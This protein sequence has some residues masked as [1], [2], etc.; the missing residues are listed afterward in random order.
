M[1]A[2]ISP[3]ANYNGAINATDAG[4]FSIILVYGFAIGMLVASIV[5]AQRF[6][7]TGAGV[8]MGGL[9]SL[10]AFAYRNTGGRLSGGYRNIIDRLDAAAQRSNEEGGS[11]TR[12][13]LAE[14]GR[15]AITAPA[16]GTM[17]ARAYA[18]RGAKYGAGGTSRSDV[19]SFNEQSRSRADSANAVAGL[20]AAFGQV[21]D[22]DPAVRDAARERIR[23]ATAKQLSDLAKTDGGRQLITTNAGQLSKNQIKSLRNSKDEHI[24][25][26]FKNQLRDRDRAA[27][28]NDL[29]GNGRN[30]ELADLRN[31]TKDQL[32]SI[33]YDTLVEPRNAARLTKKN[34]DNLNEL[35]GDGELE[36]DQI[37]NIRDAR[38]N[39]HLAI[40]SGNNNQIGSSMT[41]DDL[42]ANAD[43][44]AELHEDVIL[45]LAS[46]LTANHIRKIAEKV[47]TNHH[48]RI[49]QAYE[50]NGVPPQQPAQRGADGQYI[51]NSPAE[52]KWM[53][54]HRD[55]V[56]TNFGT[57]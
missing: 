5:V 42:L 19:K 24:S 54:L 41:R 12:R 49:R 13:R 29:V 11:F 52:Q 32:G 45:A 6:S 46:D 9:N 37:R 26:D 10:K 23:S 38:R 3:G 18:E 44:T 48:Q 40:A 30:G 50:R 56:G 34:L 36:P 39:A 2:G 22:P 47:D 57:A 16:G 55:P 53:F 25:E 51:A 14:I 21:N 28:L 43:A 27:D 4:A 33:G 8:T 20:R 35:R 31:A 1:R 17:N 7:I 15:T